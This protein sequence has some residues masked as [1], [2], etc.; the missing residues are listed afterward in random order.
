M[1]ILERPISQ[2]VVFSAKGMQHKGVF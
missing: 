1:R 2:E